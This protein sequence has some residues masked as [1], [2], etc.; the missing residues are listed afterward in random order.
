MRWCA[1]F[2]TAGYLC[3]PDFTRTVTE[4]IDTEDVEGVN[5]VEFHLGQGG[6]ITGEVVG[7]IPAHS[8]D[9]CL[10]DVVGQ[11]GLISRKE[12]VQV[13]VFDET[14]LLDNL[15]VDVERAE[16]F[17]LRDKIIADTFHSL[18]SNISYLL[19]LRIAKHDI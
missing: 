3:A 16:G 12:S 4:R 13:F 5:G 14:L 9:V 18:F 2:G 10:A 15:G 17:N 19:D 8:V 7:V 11:L 6:M 1:R